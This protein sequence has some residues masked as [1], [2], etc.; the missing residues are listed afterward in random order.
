M[1]GLQGVPYGFFPLPASSNKADAGAAFALF[2]DVNVGATR[3]SQFVT[4]MKEGFFIDDQTTEIEIEFVTF[5]PALQLF[6][7]V[8]AQID[9]H[10][11]GRIMLKYEYLTR[12]VH[13]PRPLLTHVAYQLCHHL[14]RLGAMDAVHLPRLCGGAAGSVHRL[15]CRFLASRSTVPSWRA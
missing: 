12:C 10:V 11:S 15:P 2:W 4:Y 3:G 5:N 8:Y 14:A 1:V 9:F 13:A 7:Y 6:A